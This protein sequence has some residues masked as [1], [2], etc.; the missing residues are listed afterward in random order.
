MMVI[1]IS[2]FIIL[3]F[4]RPIQNFAAHRLA[5]TTIKQF[6]DKYR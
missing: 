2:T 5:K 4:N 3:C 1:N 6:I